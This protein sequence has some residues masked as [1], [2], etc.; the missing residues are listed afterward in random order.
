VSV[1]TKVTPYLAV[2]GA[3]EALD[4][5]QRAFG[6]KVAD[7][8]TDDEGRIGHAEIRI[9]AARI[10]LADEHPE[11]GFISPTS[12]GGSAVMIE[13]TV[14]DVDA[15]MQRAVEA[16]ATVARPAADQDYGWRNGKLLDPFGHTWMIS[17]LLG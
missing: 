4:F 11:I 13:M 1:E 5:Y 9:G 3:A 12:L 6:A 2:K 17:T 16:G 15:V 14:P 7:Q 8:M 10:Y